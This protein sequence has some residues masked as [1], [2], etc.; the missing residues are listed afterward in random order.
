MVMF[1]PQLLSHSTLFIHLH[2]FSL[3]MFC[4]YLVVLL[5]MRC[6]ARA[7]VLSVGFFRIVV[8]AWFTLMSS[9][10]FFHISSS[11]VFYISL[12]SSYI[13]FHLFSSFFFFLLF[14]Y[15]LYKFWFVSY[16]LIFQTFIFHSPPISLHIFIVLQTSTY[17]YIPLSGTI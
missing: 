15:V 7:V 5:Y 9:S 4:V 11:S 14:V 12:S 13:L 3:A 1:V 2:S 6:A 8:V 17:P 16:P 10:F